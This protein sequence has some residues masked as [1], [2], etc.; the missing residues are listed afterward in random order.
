MWDNYLSDSPLGFSLLLQCNCAIL[1]QKYQSVTSAV[2]E[3]LDSNNI[4]QHKL[5]SKDNRLFHFV[6][7]FFF[8][9]VGYKI[10]PSPTQL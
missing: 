8:L 1:W 3:I 6:K 10:T 5:P 9:P 7:I 2:A 4:P